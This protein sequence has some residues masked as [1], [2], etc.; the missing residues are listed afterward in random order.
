ME[1]R[2]GLHYLCHVGGVV[3]HPGFL[4][5]GS[6]VV[7]HDMWDLPGPGIESVS[8]ALADG[9]FTTEPLGNQGSPLIPFKSEKIS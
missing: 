7:A 6:T 9:F 8:P 1:H 3:V 4:S 2:H 5:T